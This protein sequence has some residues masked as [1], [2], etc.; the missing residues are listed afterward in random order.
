M[1]ALG[2]FL[3][4]SHPES[5]LVRTLDLTGHPPIARVH[6]MAHSAPRPM[7][8]RRVRLVHKISGITDAWTHTRGPARLRRTPLV[9]STGI[10]TRG[11][12]AGLL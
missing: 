8:T 11:A 1:E 9:T 6:H 3:P 10:R 12:L 5:I 2:S 7:L 4:V